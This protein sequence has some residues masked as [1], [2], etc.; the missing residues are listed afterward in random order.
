[1]LPVIDKGQ[2]IPPLLEAALEYLEHGLEHYLGGSDKDRRLTILHLIHAVELTLKEKVLRTGKSIYRPKG[3]T[4][5]NIQEAFEILEAAGVQIPEKQYLELIHDER[6]AI[7]HKFSTPTE[8]TTRFYVEKAVLFFTSFLSSELGTPIGNHLP[9][10]YLQLLSIGVGGGD[11]PQARAIGM[12]N[13]AQALVSVSPGSAIMAA[14]AAL[15]VA[16]LEHFGHA[17]RE[18]A[19]DLLGHREMVIAFRKCR[20]LEERDV[21]AYLR[22]RNKRNAVAHERDAPS[23]REARDLLKHA[24]TL[25]DK[26][27]TTFYCDDSPL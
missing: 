26:L 14:S 2:P 3:K 21:E 15:E 12:L 25:V 4:T 5:I 1:M 6:N 8:S 24:S 18:G 13:E 23:E 22:I 17:A 16:A 27:A 10:R 19:I 9:D 20:H 11:M 7:Q